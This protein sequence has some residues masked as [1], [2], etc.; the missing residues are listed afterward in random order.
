MSGLWWSCSYN[1]ALFF[2]WCDGSVP[3]AERQVAD[4]AMWDEGIWRD[5][6]APVRPAARIAANGIRYG[7]LPD[8]DV[9]VLDQM[10]PILFAHEGLAEE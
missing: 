1:P 5:A 3:E 7:G 8:D 4:A 2:R 10:L 9:A 6:D